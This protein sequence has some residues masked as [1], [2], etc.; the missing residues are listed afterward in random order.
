MVWGGALG[1]GWIGHLTR[2][3]MGVVF[4]LDFLM[5][6]ILLSPPEPLPIFLILLSID[7]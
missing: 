4:Q 5:C 1:G 6:Y 3:K 2:D 7:T